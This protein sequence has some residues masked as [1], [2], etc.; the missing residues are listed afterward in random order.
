MGQVTVYLDDETEE[1]ARAAASAEGIPLS[2]WVARRI[3]RR[4]R[5]DWP[6]AVRA[7]AGAWPDMPTAE[8]IR[9]AK[10]KDIARQR[11]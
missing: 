11:V 9:E 6:D 4:A 2:K 5:S 7:L 3:Q 10:A 1:L 8:T